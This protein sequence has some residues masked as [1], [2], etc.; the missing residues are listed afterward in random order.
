MHTVHIPESPPMTSMNL[1][2]LRVTF[3][4]LIPPQEKGHRVFE[5]EKLN[6][7]VEAFE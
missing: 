4:S 2:V 3:V 5:E 1:T 6:S 7:D